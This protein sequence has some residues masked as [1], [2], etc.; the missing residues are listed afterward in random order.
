METRYANNNP[1]IFFF[2]IA[3][4]LAWGLMGLV[5]AQNYGCLSLAI[6]VEPLLIIGSWV[7]N[8]A[9]FLVIV[10]ILKRKGGI[11]HLVKGWLKFNVPA[12]WYVVTISPLVLA[13]L[14]ILI[15]KLIYDV[16]PVAEVLY[17]PVGLIAM[18]I[19][20]TITGAMGEELGWRG[21]ALPWLQSRM[22]ALSASIVLGV[23][24]VLW[25][26]PLWFAGLGFEE[27]PYV[28]Y[29]ITGISFTVL[30][31]WACNNSG[32]SLV[33]ASLFHLTLNI[34]VN[35][36]GN[37]ALYIHAF[38]FMVLALIVVLVYGTSTLSKASEVPVNKNT[39]EW[40]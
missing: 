12:F 15:Y 18:I 6:P 20:I 33:I 23:I 17:D 29:A 38:L 28:A 10:I 36:I 27:F 32:G 35:I 19:M 21:F 5:I 24:W 4:I 22:S 16:A 7:P 30:V 39:C 40:T 2:V 14:S 8:I 9:A 13:A 11:R 26:T 34:S 37:K 25:H 3:F 31:T 1:L